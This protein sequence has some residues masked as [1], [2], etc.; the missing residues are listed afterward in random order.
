MDHHVSGW[1]ARH[2]RRPGEPAVLSVTGECTLPA[3]YRAVLTV[4]E[5]QGDDASQLHL[6]LNINIPSGRPPTAVENR[7]TL[8]IIFKLPT[9]QQCS[10]LLITDVHADADTTEDSVWTVPVK[11]INW[12][13]VA[14]APESQ[15]WK[16]EALAHRQN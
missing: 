2:I 15:R 9:E 8:N 14:K 7:C 6:D 5:K 4:S 3:I 10:S 11:L 1:N 12:G 13:T 16:G